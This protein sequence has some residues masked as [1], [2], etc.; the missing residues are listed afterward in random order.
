MPKTA[1]PIQYRLA[2]MAFSRLYGAARIRPSGDRFHQHCS[3]APNRHAFNLETKLC[4]P[5]LRFCFT[6]IRDPVQVRGHARDDVAER[7]EVACVEA[8]FRLGDNAA[9]DRQLFVAQPF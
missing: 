1:R 3:A 9:G 5:R 8:L 2:V 7:G 4:K 6:L